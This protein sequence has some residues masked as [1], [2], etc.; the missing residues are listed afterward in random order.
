MRAQP[1]T[2]FEEV[3]MFLVG[4][5]GNKAC[6]L[7]ITAELELAALKTVPMGK[8]HSAIYKLLDSGFVQSQTI[9]HARRSRRK[10][11]IFVPSEEGK[12]LFIEIRNIAPE[13]LSTMRYQ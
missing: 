4:K 10:K 9:P 2:E 7:N 1:L 3:V 12:R 8:V 11:R 6:V 5:L 13:I